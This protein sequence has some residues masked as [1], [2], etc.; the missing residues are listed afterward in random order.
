MKRCFRTGRYGRWC[1]TCGYL[2]GIAEFCLCAVITN[3][4]GL[5]CLLTNSKIVNDCS[6][7]LF[8]KFFVI[9][10]VIAHFIS[11][12]L[13]LNHVENVR[14]KK[15]EANVKGI[16]LKNRHILPSYMIEIV[17]R[18]SLPLT[19]N[20][21]RWCCWQTLYVQSKYAPQ[22]MSN[23]LSVRLHDCC[24]KILKKTHSQSCLKLKLY[25]HAM[26]HLIEH[27]T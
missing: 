3:L 1:G 27:T 15:N 14:L 11:T 24:G 8:A 2:T 12:V 18:N 6:S 22:C 4:I 5:A 25:L 20:F 17:K 23:P 7:G 16:T 13:M 9:W 26:L 19:S 21:E 10:R